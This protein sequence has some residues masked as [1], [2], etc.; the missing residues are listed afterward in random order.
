M[1]IY[2]LLVQYKNNMTDVISIIASFATCFTA[3]ITL[4]TVLEMKREREESHKPVLSFTQSISIKIKEMDGKICF[5]GN[6]FLSEKIQIGNIGTGIAKDF[7]IQ[8][9]IDYKKIVSLINELSANKSIDFIGKKAI[10]FKSQ[11]DKFNFSF[12]STIN[13]NDSFVSFDFIRNDEKEIKIDFPAIL[14]NLLCILFYLVRERIMLNKFWSN[15]RYL[16]SKPF[17]VKLKL[18]YKD[19]GGKKYKKKLYMYFS[20]EFIVVESNK[21]RRENNTLNVRIGIK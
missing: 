2:D 7:N 6:P 18:S 8:Y 11:D 17:P 14:N 9:M 4:I 15:A 13:D 5:N 19:I 20:F 10:E 3:F 16:E 1:R 12:L 21:Q